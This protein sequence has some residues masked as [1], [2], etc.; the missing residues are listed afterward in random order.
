MA[1]ASTSD[2]GDRLGRVLS[3]GEEQSVQLLLDGAT[4]VIA[5]AAGRDDAWATDL[6]PVPELI[7]FLAIEVAC[8]AL[9]NPNQLDSLQE[10]LGQASYSARF[11]DAGLMLTDT[12]Q[13]LVTAALYTGTGSSRVSSIVDD[14]L[15]MQD[16][17]RVNDSWL[18]A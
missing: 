8:R 11:R 15:D 3:A 16:D 12:E 9:A 17:G 13:A 2:V 5:H 1:F 10:T 18:T 6:D 4:A 14:V 7:R